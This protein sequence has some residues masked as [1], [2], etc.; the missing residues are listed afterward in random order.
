MRVLTA[1]NRNLEEAVETG[2][3]RT[4]LYYR[5]NVISIH[6]PPLRER[7]DDIPLLASQ[8]LENFSRKNKKDIKGFD[9]NVMEILINV[10]NVP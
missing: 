10:R 3:F 7:K 1:T 5:L 9:Q 2:E 8:C 4:D 6:M